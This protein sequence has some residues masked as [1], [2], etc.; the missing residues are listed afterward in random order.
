MN[1]TP[2]LDA[3]FRAAAVRE[4]IVDIRLRPRRLAGR[5]RSS[6]PRPTVVLCR[7]SYFARGTARSSSSATSACGSCAHRS[8]TCAGSWTS[9]S[10]ARAA[11]SISRST[12]A[13]SRSPRMSC[14]SWRA[15]PYGATTTYGALASASRTAWSSTRRRHR[16]E[17]EPDPDRAAVPS[18]RRR[19]RGAHRVRRRA[20]REAAPASTR[21]SELRLGSVWWSSAAASAACSPCAA[22]AARTST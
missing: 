18:R 9:I 22:C 5:R 4:G 20:R 14:A 1:V 12:C 7:I 17:P 13:S 10:K 3:R 19:E 21:R 6:S 8:T 15:V 16:H 11:T 2:E